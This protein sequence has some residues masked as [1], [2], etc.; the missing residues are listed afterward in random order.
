[1][2]QLT[3]LEKTVAGQELIQI[4]H[5]QGKQENK[6]EITLN[7][8]KMGLLTEEQIAKATNLSLEEVKKLRLKMR[9]RR[10]KKN[11]PAEA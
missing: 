5:L 9:G 3:P 4:G 2:I 7:L 1:M 6:S 8:L 11:A 10:G